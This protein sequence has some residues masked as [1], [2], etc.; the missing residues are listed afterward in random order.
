MDKPQDL[1]TEYSDSF[2][3]TVVFKLDSQTKAGDTSV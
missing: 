1:Q 3:V 2:S